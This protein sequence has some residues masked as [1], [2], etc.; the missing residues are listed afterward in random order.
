MDKG[1]TPPR[2]YKQGHALQ[3]HAIDTPPKRCSSR[4]LALVSVSHM[5]LSC[6]VP[7]GTA[8]WLLVQPRW[9]LSRDRAIPRRTPF[10]GKWGGK[11]AEGQRRTGS[12][13][14]ILELCGLKE[15]QHKPGGMPVTMV[16]PT[17]VGLD[18]QAGA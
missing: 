17:F 18:A 11:G 4:S 2:T 7:G 6:R 13:P 16:D 5:A 1:V 14:S 15:E 9:L 12:S 3:G 10:L 8:A